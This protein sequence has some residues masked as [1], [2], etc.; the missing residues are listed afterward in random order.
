MTETASGSIEVAVRSSK[1]VEAMI[2]V[3]G[4]VAGEIPIGFLV[5]TAAMRTVG[6]SS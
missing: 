5:G 6:N 3:A 4:T 2:E 1:S